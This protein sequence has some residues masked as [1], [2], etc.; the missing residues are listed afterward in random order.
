MEVHMSNTAYRY[1]R[2]NR[3][4]KVNLD[5]HIYWEEY[6][7]I[8]DLRCTPVECIYFIEDCIQMDALFRINPKNKAFNLFVDIL[9]EVFRER[10]SLNKGS[11]RWL[12]NDLQGWWWSECQTEEDIAQRWAS[13]EQ[14][15][16][17]LLQYPTIFNAGWVE[18]NFFKK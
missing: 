4:P 2:Y 15:G 18:R 17:L 13:Q 3:N 11:L 16:H 8:L 6:E 10:T 12:V 9:W 14:L 5:A 7:I 1:N